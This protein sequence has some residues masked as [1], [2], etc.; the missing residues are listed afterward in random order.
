MLVS[1]LVRDKFIGS[2]MKNQ[3]GIIRIVVIVIQKKKVHCQLKCRV[4]KKMHACTLIF[5]MFI[6]VVALIVKIKDD[7]VTLVQKLE[8]CQKKDCGKI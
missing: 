8:T 7:L 5:Q 1:L 3:T 4:S 2:S 6:T